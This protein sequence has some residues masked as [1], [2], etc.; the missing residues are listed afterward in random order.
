MTGG[1]GW[2]G[3][4]PSGYPTLGGYGFGPGCP[5]EEAKN[6]LILEQLRASDKKQGQKKKGI[7]L[8]TQYLKG[9][10]KVRK[11]NE[12]EGRQTCRAEER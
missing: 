5:G 10:A 3:L 2:A 7:R 4:E 6:N 12:A 8:L 11:E 1:G 9:N